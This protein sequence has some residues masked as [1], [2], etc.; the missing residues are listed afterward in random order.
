M[1]WRQT[2]ALVQHDVLTG[3]LF[4]DK[5]LKDLLSKVLLQEEFAFHAEEF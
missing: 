1:N 5:E 4:Q 3:P 2:W